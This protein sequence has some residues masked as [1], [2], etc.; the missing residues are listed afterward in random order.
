MR[1]L[2]LSEMSSHQGDGK[3]NSP[4]TIR[5]HTAISPVSSQ[6][7]SNPHNLEEEA[8]LS[9]TQTTNSQI[10]K[11]ISILNLIRKKEFFLLTSFVLK[12]NLFHLA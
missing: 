4:S 11:T 1:F 9:A 7:G 10:Q 6:K 8:K 3:L 5:R 2:A 12:E